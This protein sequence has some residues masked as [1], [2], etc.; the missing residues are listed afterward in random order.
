M[1][2]NRKEKV[3]L[4]ETIAGVQDISTLPATSLNIY[5]SYNHGLDSGKENYTTYDIFVAH[6]LKILLTYIIFV[7]MR[8]FDI[9]E[10]ILHS[11]EL[12]RILR[13]DVKYLI[14]DYVK[15]SSLLYFQNLL[16]EILFYWYIATS[17]PGLFWR[18]FNPWSGSPIGLNQFLQHVPKSNIPTSL[19]L[20][21]HYHPPLLKPP[22]DIPQPY[23]DSDRKI[24]VPQ[25][26]DVQYA[27]AIRS[28]YFAQHQAHVASERVR[29]LRE[30]GQFVTWCCLVPSIETV[31]IV[32]KKAICWEVEADF[33]DSVKN[34]ILVELVALSNTCDPEEL[35]KLKGLLPQI[36]VVNKFTKATYTVNESEVQPRE[37][38]TELEDTLE[39]IIAVY[40]DQRTLT[41]ILCDSR[42]RITNYKIVTSKS[43]DLKADDP[44]FNIQ[45]PPTP[46]YIIAPKST[47]GFNHLLEG[48][49]CVDEDPNKLNMAVVHFLHLKFG[50]PFFSRSLYHYALEKPY[51]PPLK[52]EPQANSTFC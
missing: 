8:L 38:T 39:N 41:V 46:E 5:S 51:A 35:T 47:R 11:V 22:P 17:I 32:E 45:F 9:H 6:V 30:I 18:V 19:G 7:Y 26:K 21:L 27:I 34:A 44:E 40:Q 2:K 24:Q 48:Y 33:I 49:V 36:V 20:I 25:K 12:F 23:L 4:Y 31:T 3:A 50:F 1:F 52:D 29:L 37:V 15:I 13:L 10:W 42:V 28:E 43:D 16:T 14:Y